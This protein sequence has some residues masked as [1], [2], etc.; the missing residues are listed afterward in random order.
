VKKYRIIIIAVAAILP[1]LFFFSLSPCAAD[2][3]AGPQMPLSEGLRVATQESRVI[4][5]ATFS[6]EMASQDINIAISRYFP[7]INAQANYTMLAYQPGAIFGSNK[8]PTS[9]QDFPSYGVNFY[10][11]LFDFF[12]RESLYKA[13]RESFELTQRDIF[14]T[15]NIIALEFINAYFTLLESDQMISVGLKEVEALESH[16]HT[17]RDLFDAGTITRNDLLQAE[18][19]LSDARQRLLTLKNLRAFYLSN[20]NKILVRPLNQGFIPVEPAEEVSPLPVLERAWEAAALNRAEIKISDYELKINELKETAKTA[21]FFP[22]LFAQGGYDYTKNQY[23]THEDNWSLIFGLKFNIFNGGATKAELSKLRLRSEQI[24]EDR[25]RIIDD[26]KLEVERYYLDEKS[27]GENILVTKEAVGQAVE[28]MR[29]NRVRYEE[30]VG[31]ATDVLDAIS[32]L[33]LAEKNHYK[34]LYDMKRAHA[35]LLYAAG[36]DL[37]LS[38]K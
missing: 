37:T 7:S 27:A 23:V 20:I 8:V 34:A 16:S 18:V 31:T 28:N 3:T 38:Y 26:I 19:R 13:S 22:S 33:T 1:T 24:R 4:R 11:T 5:I 29:I 12:A 32:L 6:R 21:E 25:N 15:K 35:G 30:G 14:R 17:A 2:E 9:N 10:Q 36:E